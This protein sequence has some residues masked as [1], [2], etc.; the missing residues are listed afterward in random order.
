MS[1]KKDWAGRLEFCSSTEVTKQ[2]SNVPLNLNVSQDGSDSLTATFWNK[3][4]SDFS[5]WIRTAVLTHLEFLK[6]SSAIV[7]SFTCENSMKFTLSKFIYSSQ[8]SK[9]NQRSVFSSTY[10][11]PWPR[12][13]DADG[14][15]G[16]ACA[17][18]SVRRDGIPTEATCWRSSNPPIVVPSGYVNSL[19]LKMAQSK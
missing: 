16:A 13:H 2:M 5:R 11:D 7:P 8:P 6:M 19:L 4:W 9:S 10:L 14:S 12:K 1:Q 18:V 15:E 17:A 3:K